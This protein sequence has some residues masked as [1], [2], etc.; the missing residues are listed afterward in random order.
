MPI[1]RN[2]EE[3]KRMKVGVLAILMAFLLAAGIPFAAMSGTAPDADSDTVPDAS[4][5]CVN[6]PNGNGQPNPQCD[7]DTDGYGNV[8]DADVNN[9]GVVG[10]PDYVPITNNFGQPTATF[11]GA[12]V[13]CDGVIGNPDYV[14]ITNNFASPV[15]PS[16]L[17]C[18]GTSPCP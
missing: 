9:D 7:T 17:T 11:P 13:N 8:C 3:K 10:N 2:T 14:P 16:G 18:A 12:D 1:T 6:V 15:G 4:D 5:N